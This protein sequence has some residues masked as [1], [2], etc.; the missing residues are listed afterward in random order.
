[1]KAER[2]KEM[3]QI[4]QQ[5]EQYEEGTF[6]LREAV[7]EIKQ[8]KEEISVRDRYVVLLVV[9][10]KTV[11]DCFN[12]FLSDIAKL[13]HEVTVLQGQT[14]LL[15]EQNSALRLKLG[16]GPNDTVSLQELREKR[17]QDEKRLRKQNTELSLEV[18]RLKNEKTALRK[19]IVD[20][21]LALSI[22]ADRKSS[23]SDPPQNLLSELMSQK[24]QLESC[25]ELEK[26]RK[27]AC[28]KEV[29]RLNQELQDRHKQHTNTSATRGNDSTD[30]SAVDDKARLLSQ[31]SELKSNNARL[32]AKVK[33]MEGQKKSLEAKLEL[34]SAETVSLR[35]QLD[36]ARITNPPSLS[37]PH[38]H[39]RGTSTTLPL[40]GR[41]FLYIL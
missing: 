4:Q 36:T 23:S 25:L 9:D 24:S 35:D 40:T 32:H 10:C 1:M 8:K 22:S 26:Q 16:L 15:M 41:S 34:K 11:R 7:R 18:E 30:G 27:L 38:H 28:E 3:V 14:D 12:F 2:E 37:T 13:S 29:A 21:A 39:V 33:T 31:L 19:K 6:G 20:Q 17:E 5:L